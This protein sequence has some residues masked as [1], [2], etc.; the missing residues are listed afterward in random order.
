M[1]RKSI[2]ASLAAFVLFAVHAVAQ[3]IVF[4]PGTTVISPGGGNIT[5]TASITYSTTPSVLA[6]STT[7]PSGWS[8][9]SGINEPPVKPAAA[10]TGTLA[11]SYTNTDTLPSS[12]VTFNFTVAYPAGVTGL[13]PL[14]SSVVTRASIESAPIT[15]SGPTIT[16]AGA[17]STFTWV[18]DATT[19]TGNW[20]DPT[21]WSPAGT[22]PNNS[23]S[24]TYSAQISAGTA[25][26]PTSTSIALT[27]LLLLGGT[28]NGGGSLSVLG[29]N[30][31]WTSGVLSSISQL[32]VLPG[33]IMT[34]STF[35][36]HDFNQTTIVNQGVFLWQNGGALRS[37]NGG[38]FVNTA[39]GTFT[40][41]TSGTVDYVITNNFGG[42]F[43][44]SNAGSYVKSSDSTTRIE[45]PF[46]NSGNLLIES[47]TLRFTSSFGQSTGLVHVASGA[48][49]IFDNPATIAAGS[50][51]GGGTLVGNVT[52]GS[53]SGGNAV[54][55][56]GDGVGRL[57]IQ[58]NLTLLNTTKFLAELGGTTQGVTYDFVDVAGNATL[59]GALALTLQ[60]GFTPSS[61]TTFT[62][63]NSSALT[64]T[65]TN[66]PNGSRLFT[67][68]GDGS[69]IVNYTS[70][71]LTLTNFVPVP[72][73]STWALMITGLGV[74]AAGAWRR[75]K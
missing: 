75:K 18:G 53:A 67:A 30:S 21:K 33:A 43:T 47:G 27:D 45:V 46:T 35:A 72:E 54:L 10:T 52:V 57:T 42:T 48:F 63:L 3:T 69:F 56:P 15:T 8:Y 28:I 55:S 25:T 51:T 2:L 34:A 9:L 31:S 7:L 73:P 32:T 66:A 17:S 36:P 38:S 60:N 20:T 13:Q 41:T 61:A 16:L 40:D 59:G 5:F 22:V 44:F 74:L 11:W 12:P 19:H 37:G 64:G 49:G 68:A 39:S 70:T 23:G 58:G 4:T 71:S 29:T 14:P 26:I 6:F 50:V 24:S 62:L 65:F 1:L